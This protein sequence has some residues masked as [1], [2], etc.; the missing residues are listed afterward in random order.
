MTLEVSSNL[1]DSVILSPGDQLSSTVLAGDSKQS[2]GTHLPVGTGREDLPGDVTLS[3]VPLAPSLL[4][5]RGDGGEE[6]PPHTLPSPMG[7][8]LFPSSPPLLPLAQY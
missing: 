8:P 2:H 7:L 6:S 4:P 5:S 3:I 1:N